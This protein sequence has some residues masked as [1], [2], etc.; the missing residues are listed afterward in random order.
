M[1]TTYVEWWGG[2]WRLSTD[3]KS[4]ETYRE[5]LDYF[6]KEKAYWRKW[7]MTLKLVKSFDPATLPEEVR[8]EYLDQQWL[9]DEERR[10]TGQRDV[11]T[12]T[13]EAT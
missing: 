11:T 9:L 12:P 2:M 8:E 6:D 10:D 1:S 4:F 5:V 3:N 7:G 13:T